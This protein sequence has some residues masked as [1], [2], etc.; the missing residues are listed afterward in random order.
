AGLF[1][2]QDPI[3]NIAPVMI[4]IIGWVGLAFLSV[5][6]GDVWRLVNP[7][8][9]IFALAEIC[10]RRVRADAVLGFARRYPESLAAWPAF[11]LL[12][13][14]A[15]MELVERQKRPCGTRGRARRLFCAHVFRHGPV[16]T[17]DMARTGGD[18]HARFRHLCT[19]RPARSHTAAARHPR[20]YAGGRIAGRGACDVL[21]GRASGCAAGDR[22]LRRTARNSAL[23]AGRRRGPGLG[24]RTV[25][26]ARADP[27][28]RSNGAAGSQRGARGMRFAVSGGVRGRVPVDGGRCGRAR[29]AHRRGAP[30]LR[31]HPRAD[32]D[33]LSRG[34]LFLVVLP[35]RAI[36]DP[37]SVG[38]AGPRLEPLRD[39]PLS[40]GYRA[41][42]AAAAVDRGGGRG[43]ARPCVR[44][45]PLARYGASS[46][47][48]SAC[49]AEESDPDGRA[50]GQLHDAELVD[51]V[52]A[53]RRDRDALI[54]IVDLV[55]VDSLVRPAAAGYVGSADGVHL[56]AD[57]GHGEAVARR[58]HRRQPL[59]RVRLR[60]EGLVR[61]VRADQVVEVSLATNYVHPPVEYGG[62]H[63]PSWGP[64][65][66]PPRPRALLPV[67]RP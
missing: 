5:L 19:V 58:R 40:G 34:A 13:V 2:N 30:Q 20:A 47:R 22:H 25:I 29:P 7:W 39:R 49:G 59:P 9:A 11:L 44:D 26:R 4:W 6:L 21:H 16:R 57:L 1:G 38:S 24:R 33:R 8:N 55:H 51:P 60:I 52:P 15:W 63:P 53:H 14:F 62:F 18:V 61:P 27:A 64:H 46:L 50:D 32:R 37:A 3:R 54:G 48:R 36:R 28:R 41:G 35:R 42:H 56:A 66:P 23:G 12:V 17:P 10:C 67:V 31:A 43:G 65:S 45:L